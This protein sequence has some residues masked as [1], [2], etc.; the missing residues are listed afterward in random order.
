MDIDIRAK[1]VPRFTIVSHEWKLCTT[2]YGDQD[3]LGYHRFIVVLCSIQRFYHLSGERKSYGYEWRGAK[4]RTLLVDLNN[5]HEITAAASNI[6]HYMMCSLPHV[7]A[8]LWGYPL[9]ICCSSKLRQHE[10][11][12]ANIYVIKIVCAQHHHH[13]CA[14]MLSG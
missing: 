11:N 4:P 1:C 10:V 14:R 2:W 8:I 9:F 7:V 5:F 6:H 3:N 13:H 12:N